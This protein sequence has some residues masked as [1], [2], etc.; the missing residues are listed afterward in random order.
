MIEDERYD[1]SRPR[2]CRWKCG[3][4][5]RL[6]DYRRRLDRLVADSVIWMPYDEHRVHVQFQL[7]SLFSGHIRWGQLIVRHRPE[8]VLRQFGYVQTIPT[9]DVCMDTYTTEAM[10]ICWAHFLDHIIE[11]GQFAA[12]P[13]QCDVGYM[14]WFYRISHPFMIPPKDGDPP[15]HPPVLHY[16]GPAPAADHVPRPAHHEEPRRAVVHVF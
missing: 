15:R 13:A 8:R 12:F 16:V 5:L 9:V 11:R 3:K 10:D 14:E 6:R 7:I 4:A 2:A 1:E